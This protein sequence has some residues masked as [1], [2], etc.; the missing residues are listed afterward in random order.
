MHDDDS[1]P[2]SGAVRHPLARGAVLIVSVTAFVFLVVRAGAAGCRSAEPTVQAEARPA[3]PLPVSA[4]PAPATQAA[5]TPAASAPATAS[6]TASASA[7]VPR[8][9]RF[10]GGSKALAEPV[11]EDDEGK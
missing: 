3:A 11:Y 4:T 1:S 10:F 2:R 5:D 8:K 6:P 7:A 9:P